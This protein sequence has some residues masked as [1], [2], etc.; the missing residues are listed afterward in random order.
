MKVAICLSGHLRTYKKT[1]DSFKSRL[2][3]LYDSK[4]FIHTWD[5]Y[6]SGRGDISTSS[7]IDI[8]DVK[9]TYSPADL[10]V[11]P[12]RHFE[13]KDHPTLR[14]TPNPPANVVSKWYSSKKSFELCKNWENKNNEKFDVIVSCRSDMLF[15]EN[16]TLLKDPGIVYTPGGNG[17]PPGTIHDYFAFGDSGVMGTYFDVYDKF[18]SIVSELN[19]SRFRAEEVITHHLLTNRVPIKYCYIEYSLCR[20]SGEVRRMK[21]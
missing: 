15:H 3:N 2:E 1:H 10:I 12:Q 7:K 4:V 9:S 19:V 6:S 11:E 14:T 17:G 18:D 13:L 5:N 20:L 21:A 16:V 8:E